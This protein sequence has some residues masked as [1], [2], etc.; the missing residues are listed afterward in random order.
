MTDDPDQPDES[1]QAPGARPGFAATGHSD[2]V[3]CPNCCRLAR[4]TETRMGL[5]YYACDLCGSV[6][7]TP[8]TEEKE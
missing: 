8:T 5:L 1:P 7:A 4:V 2:R 3:Q 6:G